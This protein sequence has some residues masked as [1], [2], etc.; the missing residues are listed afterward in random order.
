MTG[1]G[2]RT[3]DEFTLKGI[4]IKMMVELNERYSDVTHRL[5]LVRS[6]KGD[7]PTRAS[8]FKGQSG[9]KMLDGFNTERYTIIF[10]KI[11]K[12]VSRDQSSNGAEVTTTVPPVS[13]GF[14]NA[15]GGDNKLSRGTRII[16]VYIPGLK[17]AKDG[18]LK[19]EDLSTS[20]VKFYDYTLVL[21]IPIYFVQL[22]SN[23][24]FFGYR[25]I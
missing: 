13:H 21:W 2:N 1:D 5:I 16:R 6:A 15:A 4:S 12:L 23:F 19:Y 24:H 11:F 14:V 9:N 18:V 22:R 25:I 17:I 7:T 20:Q 8:L 10:S 3:G